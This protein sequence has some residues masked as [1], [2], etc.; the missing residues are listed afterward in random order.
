MHAH[1]GW[2]F[3]G[4]VGVKNAAP[5]SRIIVEQNAAM[6]GGNGDVTS[7][8]II[9]VWCCTGITTVTS[10]SEAKQRRLQQ[11]TSSSV[12]G[13]WLMYCLHFPVAFSLLFP[14]SFFVVFTIFAC[15]VIVYLCFLGNVQSDL[16]CYLFGQNPINIYIWRSGRGQPEGGVYGQRSGYRQS[17]TEALPCSPKGTAAPAP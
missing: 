6:M 10:V 2:A 7:V 11:L 5:G 17:A 1:Q 9:F 15:T 16:F 14:C 3:S 13:D 12:G 8:R 4:D